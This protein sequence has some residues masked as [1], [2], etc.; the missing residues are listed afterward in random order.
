LTAQTGFKMIRTYQPKYD[1]PINKLSKLLKLNIYKNKINFDGGMEQ[2]F[3]Y[4]NKQNASDF[5]KHDYFMARD[6]V[7]NAIPFKISKSKISINL[8]I[9]QGEV[10]SHTDGI[11][12]SSILVPIMLDDNVLEVNG[13]EKSLKL[14]MMYRFND[15]LVHSYWQ[16]DGVKSAFIVL[17]FDRIK[18]I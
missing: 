14:G 1:L 15:S 9:C 4:Y 5:N 7:L 12:K 18:M 13:H 11:S 8:L 17:D 2:F 6:I 16:F 10:G 3:Y